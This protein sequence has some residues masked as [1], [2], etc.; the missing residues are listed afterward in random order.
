MSVRQWPGDQGSIPDRVIPKTKKWYLDI[1]LLNTQHYKVCIKDKVIRSK[2]RS[3]ALLLTRSRSY[4]KGNLRFALDH[5]RQLSFIAMVKRCL[6]SWFA[7]KRRE[8][9]EGGNAM[10]MQS[11]F[12]H[13]KFGACRYFRKAF[14][15][16]KSR[17]ISYPMMTS[18]QFFFLRFFRFWSGISNCLKGF[19]WPQVSLDGILSLVY[20]FYVTHPL[21]WEFRICFGSLLSSSLF[22]VASPSEDA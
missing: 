18:C 15:G 10:M 9:V 20:L 17:S 22:Q 21:S 16:G 14:W 3:C 6:T 4:W 11:K 1:S 13:F 2:G 5:C 12:Q 19:L 7:S 8:E